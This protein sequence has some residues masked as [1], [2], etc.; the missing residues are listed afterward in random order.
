MRLHV[1]VS[2]VQSLLRKMV[3]AGLQAADPYRAVLRTVSLVDRRLH[4]GRKV[5]NLDKYDR[6]L[7]VGAGKASARMAQALEHIL[8]G[9]LEGG[10]VVVPT[11][12]RLGTKRIRIVEAG[13]PIPD[14]AGVVATRQLEG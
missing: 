13:H 10:F 9:Q 5:Y 2:P 4:V 12:H 6:V 3:A 7:A 14:R 1:P 8:R 11:S